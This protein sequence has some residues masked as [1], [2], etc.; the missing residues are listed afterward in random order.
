[1]NITKLKYGSLIKTVA[2]RNR[3]QNK[4]NNGN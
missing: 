2:I 3:R 1:M 4:F